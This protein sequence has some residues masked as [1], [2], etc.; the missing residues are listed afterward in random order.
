[1]STASKTILVSLLKSTLI[2]SSLILSDW[3]WLH[4]ILMTNICFQRRCHC[5]TRKPCITQFDH[6][7]NIS[8]SLFLHIMD[9]YF[10][11][12]SSPLRLLASLLKVVNIF[13]QANAIIH[14]IVSYPYHL[15]S[16]VVIWINKNLV[17]SYHIN[18]SI[19]ENLII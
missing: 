4:V 10:L 17:Y 2:S 9:N 18:N 13:Q 15:M 14:E 8:L 16:R 3:P 11:G 1:M 19:N 7:L 12:W 6:I 5:R